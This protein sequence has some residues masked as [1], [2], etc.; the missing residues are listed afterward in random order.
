M[1]LYMHLC[2]PLNYIYGHREREMKLCVTH[3]EVLENSLTSND[4]NISLV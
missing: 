3:T 2:M 4:D 1:H